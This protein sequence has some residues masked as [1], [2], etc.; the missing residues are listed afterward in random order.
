MSIFFDFH[1]V[2]Q[3]SNLN[4]SPG[5]APPALTL[6]GTSNYHH[7]SSSIT[8]RQRFTKSL[9][10]NK[11]KLSSI[12]RY[13]P[14]EASKPGPA[15]EIVFQWPHWTT[16]AFILILVASVEAP[17]IHP[18]LDITPTIED[19][20]D[21]QQ[22]SWGDL[23]SPAGNNIIRILFQNVNGV[24]RYPATHSEI[25]Q[26][27]I[28]IQSHITGLC[29][30]N[31]NWRNFHFQDAW[32]HKMQSGFTDLCFTHSSCDKGVTGM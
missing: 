5:Y 12:D 11:F 7:S 17:V 4:F 14:S 27:L 25:Q 9:P 8:Y 13:R 15:G 20:L 29:E 1:L 28:R 24:T 31:V 19:N 26:N 6:M 10:A 18:S 23:L 3:K 30:T 32:E 22:G 16:W 21:P 2:S